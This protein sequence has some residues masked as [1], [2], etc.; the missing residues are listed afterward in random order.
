MRITRMYQGDDGVSHFED[1]EVA[2]HLTD[3]GGMSRRVFPGQAFFRR[4]EPG[5]SL[6]WHNAPGRVMIIIIQG[7]VEVELTG[8]EKRRFGPGDICM[9]EDVE[10][11]GHKSV[12]V[13]GPRL[14][15]MISMADDWDV[16]H[17]A[18]Q[19]GP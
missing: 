3:L 13:E 2:L 17:W 14:S 18:R 6:D 5:L 1:V 15:L 19:F 16:R 8:G 11:P 9:A 10:G 12:D 7:A 4:T